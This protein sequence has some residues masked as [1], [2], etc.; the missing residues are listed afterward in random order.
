MNA[1][2]SATASPGADQQRER[3]LPALLALTG[4]VLLLLFLAYVIVMVNYPADQETP[5]G[6]SRPSVSLFATL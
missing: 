4:A 1:S 6:I 3:Y 5:L 2:S